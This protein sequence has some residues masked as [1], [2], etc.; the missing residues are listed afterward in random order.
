M[1]TL[2]EN[3]QS[4]LSRLRHKPTALAWFLSTWYFH[5]LYFTVEDNRK[6][7]QVFWIDTQNE[8]V[9]EVL[10]FTFYLHFPLKYLRHFIYNMH[11]YFN[12]YISLGEFLCVTKIKN[13][14]DDK[15]YSFGRVNPLQQMMAF[16]P[17]GLWLT[18]ICL[19]KSVGFLCLIDKKIH[20]SCD[21]EILKNN[22]TVA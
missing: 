14:N 20:I 7:N 21:N 8:A 5:L 11:L 17:W 12:V 6:I 1:Y 18:L 2:V 19:H 13:T 15:T 16:G 10:Q 9:I 22:D 3:R 4:N